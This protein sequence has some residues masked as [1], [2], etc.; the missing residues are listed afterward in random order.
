MTDILLMAD[1]EWNNNIKLV[2][3]STP[4]CH[5]VAIHRNMQCHGYQV[6]SKSCWLWIKKLYSDISVNKSE[7]VTTFHSQTNNIEVYHTLSNIHNLW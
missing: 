6:I 3:A 5:I 4:L 7:N 1:M 2:Q